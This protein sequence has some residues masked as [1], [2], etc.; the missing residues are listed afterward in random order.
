MSMRI[1]SAVLAV[2]AAGCSE[3]HEPPR[4]TIDPTRALHTLSITEWES[5]C[6][7]NFEY[8]GST[9]LLVCADGV[10]SLGSDHERCV[11]LYTTVPGV[12]EP[13]CPT[14]VGTL[15]DCWAGSIDDCRSGVTSPET[16]AACEDLGFCDPPG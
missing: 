7:W 13:E 3:S 2:L 4:P 1:V 16:E 12:F 8:A 14:T 9:A 6:L 5:L 15:L 11:D 10:G